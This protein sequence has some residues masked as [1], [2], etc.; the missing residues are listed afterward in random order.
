M[1]QKLKYYSVVEEELFL[2]LK[3]LLSKLNRKKYPVILFSPPKRIY[4]KMQLK[5][6]LSLKSHST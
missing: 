6:A 1:L 2:F 5:R 4:I 3:E